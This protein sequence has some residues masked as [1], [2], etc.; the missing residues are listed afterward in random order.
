MPNRKLSLAAMIVLFAALSFAARAETD[1]RDYAGISTLP[2]RTSLF[3]GYYRHQSSS[4]ATSLS[5]DLAIFRGVYILKWGN[6]TF[7]PIDFFLPVADVTVYEPI[8]GGGGVNAA[9]HASGFADLTYLPTLIYEFPESEG[10]SSLIGAS[11]YV[12]AP[13]GSYDETKLVNVGTHRWSVKPEI[14]L[15]QRFARRY[16]LE[17]I[18]NITFYGDNN[19]LLVAPNTR[20]TLSQSATP[21]LEAHF[22]ADINDVL[23][24]G[25]SYY[26]F[27]FGRTSISETGA[28][29]AGESTVNTLR[30]TLGLRVEKRSVIYLQYNQDLHASGGG[31]VSRFW[32]ARI[33]HAF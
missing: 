7:V 31:T 9:L 16:T 20:L 28:I 14:A 22:M 23:E 15:G 25:A 33:V 24:M 29:L 13:V 5:Q 8:P 17:L 19:D 1:P 26:I 11:V 12:T 18:G 30:G 6:L 32:G 21:G 2:S 27:G 3:L 4:D 10:N